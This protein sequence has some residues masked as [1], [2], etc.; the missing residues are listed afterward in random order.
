MT[1]PYRLAAWLL[2]L[3][4]CFYGIGAY[5]LLDDNEGLYAAIARDMLND[6]QYIIPHLNGLPYLEKPPMLYWLTAFSM[7]LFGMGSGAA[8]LIP[9]LALFATACLM[10]HWVKSVS[11]SETAG[12]AATLM[13]VTSLPLLVI[14]RMLL[15]DMVMTFFLSAAL[16]CFYYWYSN[17]RQRGLPGYYGFLA[18][19]VLTKGFVTLILGG[20][21]VLLFLLWQRSPVSVYRACLSLPGLALFLCIAAPWHIAASLMEPGFAWFYFINEHVLRF[22]N[23]REPH[24]YY[25]GPIWYYLPRLLAYLLPWTLFLPLL[26]RKPSRLP[27]P[28]AAL[29]RFLWSWFLFCLL[30]FSLSGAKANYYMIAGMPP[31]VM[32]LAMRTAFY[33]ESGNRLTAWI[34]TACLSL[35]AIPLFAAGYACHA[36]A[37]FAF[38]SLLSWPL[39]IT[40]GSFSLLAIL[41]CWRLPPRWRIP[42]IASPI[43]PLLPLLIA[44]INQSGDL[45]SQK[46]VGDYL[47][48]SGYERTAIYREFE[49]LSALAFYMQKPLIVVDSQSN[50]LLYGQ[51]LR[52]APEEFLSLQEW[53]ETSPRLPL[54]VVNKHMDTVL[55]LLKKFGVSNSCVLQRFEHVAVIGTCE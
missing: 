19:A 50:D 16:Y 32:L 17:D 42:L 53:A 25:T 7:S 44:G 30:F 24:D 40:A 23:Q 21:S 41:L 1:M 51:H 15:C 46:P 22:L 27:K 12:F 54:V 29:Q 3:F 35:L 4:A 6:G 20:G 47:Q 48:A 43:L 38:C 39:A 31:L 28:Q 10:L 37:A 8:H 49:K 33:P 9:A 13:M 52:R 11:R 2:I 14:G 18:L 45:V 5:P 34:A 36:G 55:P 26:A